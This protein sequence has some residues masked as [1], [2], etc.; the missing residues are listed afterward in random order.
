MSA[1]QAGRGG[2]ATGACNDGLGGVESERR[3]AERVA[4]GQGTRWR[5]RSTEK[6][7]AVDTNQLGKPDVFGD[8]AKFHDW[9]LLNLLLVK[10][11]CSCINSRLGAF[12]QTSEDSNALCLNAAFDVGNREHSVQLFFILLLLTTPRDL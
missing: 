9:K 2:A 1:E 5:S 11:H 6:T 8:G 10:T 3:L 12:M 7:H 4:G